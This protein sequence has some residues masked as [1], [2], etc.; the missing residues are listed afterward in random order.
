MIRASR[1]AVCAPPPNGSDAQGELEL[2]ALDVRSQTQA[3]GRVGVC[4]YLVVAAADVE[5]CCGALSDGL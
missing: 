1:R 3:L 2:A 5:G 4:D